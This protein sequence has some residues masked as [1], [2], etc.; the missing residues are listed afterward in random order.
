MA[1]KFVSIEEA[2]RL[3]GVSV[4]EVSRLVD[5][6]KLFPMRDGAAFK[7]KVEEV[8]R[9]AA[10]IGDD[11]SRSESLSLDLDLPT[12]GDDLAIGDAVDPGSVLLGGAD[13]GSFSKEPWASNS[14][15]ASEWAASGWSSATAPFN[16]RTSSMRPSHPMPP[17]TSR[18]MAYGA[19]PTGW[20]SRW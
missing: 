12:P 16:T 2:A 1:G 19:G 20:A 14:T 8:E 17:S 10:R 9:V 6:K 7:F 5:R 18:P 15:P 4:D 11:S 13:A 3:I